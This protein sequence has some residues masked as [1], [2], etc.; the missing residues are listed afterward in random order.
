MS[1]LI[2]TVF[3]ETLRRKTSIDGQSSRVEQL[4]RIGAA[5]EDIAAELQISLKG[6]IA[7][8]FQ[9]RLRLLY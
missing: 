3:P 5:E 4:A 8:I 2:E 9:R 7:R 1:Q 6:L